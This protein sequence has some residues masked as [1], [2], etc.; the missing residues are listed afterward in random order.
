MPGDP[1]KTIY[2]ALTRTAVLDG[3]GAAVAWLP[4]WS[5]LRDAR[6]DDLC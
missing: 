2:E 5:Q 4:A 3:G 6:S 1:R